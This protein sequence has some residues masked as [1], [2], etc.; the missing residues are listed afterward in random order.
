M[1]VCVHVFQ[2]EFGKTAPEESFLGDS[3][4]GIAQKVSI[5]VRGISWGT[6]TCVPGPVSGEK[7]SPSL[8]HLRE[9]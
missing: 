1:K 2:R 9:P 4:Q 5:R 3:P 6:Q 8:R 7:I